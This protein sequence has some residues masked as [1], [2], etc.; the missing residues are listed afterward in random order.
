MSATGRRSKPV[1]LVPRLAA[2]PPQR[3]SSGFTLLEVMVVVVIVG[4]LAGF[5]ALALNQASE[6]PLRS[7]SER[8]ADWLQMV[9]DSALLQGVAYGLAE[10]QGEWQLLV[11]YRG[12]WWPAAQPEPFQWRQPVALSFHSDRAGLAVQPEQGDSEPVVA[13][14]PSGQLQPAGYFQLDFQQRDSRWRVGLTA[15][16]ATAPSAVT[17]SAQPMALSP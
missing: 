12:Q 1:T 17:F 2:V 15:G 9:T 10:Q 11:Y 5:S 7:E 6:R 14:L 8:F 4:L 16:S 3:P 13:L